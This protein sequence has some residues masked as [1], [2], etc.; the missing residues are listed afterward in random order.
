MSR[1]S[2]NRWKNPPLVGTPI[3]SERYTSTQ[4]MESE[5]E[6]IWTKVWL[7][8]ARA[9]EIPNPGDYT[10]EEVGS[11]SFITIR[12][13]DGGV[14]TFYNV[15][16]HRGSRLTFAQ[17]GYANRFVCPYHGWEWARSGILEQVPDVEDFRGGSPCGKLS[18]VEVRCEIHAGFVFITM[19]ENAPSLQEYLG[20]VWDDWE[21]YHSDNWTRTSAATVAVDCNWKVPQDNSC[22]SYHLR[23]V[24]P[25]GEYWIEHDYKQCVFDWCVEGHNRMAIKMGIPAKSLAEKDLHI[26]DQLASML[27][28][29]GLNPQDFEGREFETRESLQKAKRAMGEDRGYV[30]GDLVDDQLTDA[31]HYNIFPNV[32]ISYSGCE[33]VSMQRMRPHP[34]NPAKCFYDNF[35]Y[36]AA[37][38]ESDAGL[39]GKGGK[40]W[41]DEGSQREFFT[42]GDR[43]MNRRIADQ[44][45]SIVT[46]QQ[47]GLASRAYAGVN[48][49]AQEDRVQRFHDVINRYLESC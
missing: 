28:P 4:F 31:Y 3:T 14:R 41:L 11:E 10:V 22:E 21:Q 32:T 30:I 17:E 43:L 5:W 26:D 1:A 18:L 42:Y 29:W 49:L 34:T 12:Q 27:E 44:D 6:K 37:G 33:Y 19:N 8:V 38:S 15:C 35:T 24:H 13:D 40:E 45:L 23:S 9:P 16:Q 48:L 36:G 2:E 7:L 20:P 25:Q 39:T 47:L 46:G